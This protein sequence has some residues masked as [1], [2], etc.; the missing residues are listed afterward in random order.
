[1]FLKVIQKF[2]TKLLIQGL[3]KELKYICRYFMDVKVAY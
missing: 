2:L 3:Q 1:M